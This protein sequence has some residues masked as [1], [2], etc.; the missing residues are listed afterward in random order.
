MQD[1]I[2]SLII[3]L[4]GCDYSFNLCLMHYEVKH[5]NL[6]CVV[7]EPFILH[8]VNRINCLSMIKMS[9]AFTKTLIE[10]FPVV[11]VKRSSLKVFWGTSVGAFGLLLFQQYIFLSL[12]EIALSRYWL[13]HVE[14]FL[15]F[16]ILT[17]HQ[18]GT[19]SVLIVWQ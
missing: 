1:N 6:V 11:W 3:P 5:V 15:L 19:W 9:G 8:T 2:K 4:I 7:I 14:V 18:I 13:V 17:K 10:V 16:L 12:V